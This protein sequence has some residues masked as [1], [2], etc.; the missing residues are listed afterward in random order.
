MV[1]PIRDIL[2]REAAR[3]G[4]EP[5]AR[6]AE[7][8]RRWGAVVGEK[9]AEAS[10]PVAVRGRTLV[11]GVTHSTAGQEIR[12]RRAAI[13][14]ALNGKSA[15]PVLDDIRVVARRRLDTART[16]RA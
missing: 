13:V 7:A 16:R 12:L 10:A 14:A 3:W 9:L 11:V 4:L 1:V 6:L 15:K 5:A 2:A 8:R